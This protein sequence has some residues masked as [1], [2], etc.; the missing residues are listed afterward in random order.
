[1]VS[2]FGARPRSIGAA[3]GMLLPTPARTGLSRLPKLTVAAAA[4]G[5]MV[6]GGVLAQDKSPSPTAAP[7]TIRDERALRLLKGMTDTL[8]RATTLSF[9]ARSLVPTAGPNGQWISLLGTSRVVMQRP[10]KLFVEMRGDLFPNDLYLDGKT[11]T[12]IAPNEKFYA[13]RPAAGQTVDAIIDDAYANKE[14]LF[15]FADVLPSDAYARLTRDLSSALYVGQSTIGGAKVEHL[16]LTGKALDWEIWIGTADRLPRFM[17]GAYR[18]LERNPTFWVEFSDWK[19]N[20]RI[21]PKTFTPAIPKDAKKI[22]FKRERA[23]Q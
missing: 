8:A 15:P 10:D 1:M 12:A 9:S 19:V 17:M 20:P 7:A 22:E 21:P 16:A 2:A 3:R 14:D 4:I 23:A 13:Q 6:H 5:L 18:D 11:W